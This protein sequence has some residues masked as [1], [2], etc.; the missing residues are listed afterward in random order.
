[1]VATKDNQ[2]ENRKV[3]SR[4]IKC[5][6]WAGPRRM[7]QWFLGRVEAESKLSKVAEFLFEARRMF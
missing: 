4:H 7:N 5:E 6:E 3:R 2:D 1:M